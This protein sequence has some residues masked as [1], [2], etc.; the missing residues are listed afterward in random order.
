MLVVTYD[1]QSDKLRNRFAKFMKSVGRR[2]QYSVF[3]LKNSK[4]IL[5]NVMKEVELKYQK[6]FTNVDSI[7]IF[8]LCEA[9][10]KKVKRYG[11]AAHEEEEIVIF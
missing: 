5:R 7:L 9:D 6:H 3:E 4:R 1:I 10:R 11:S 2:L 8:D